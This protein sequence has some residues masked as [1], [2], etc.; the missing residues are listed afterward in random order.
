MSG[1]AADAGAGP[2]AFGEV[3]SFSRPSMPAQRAALSLVGQVRRLFLSD[4]NDPP[5]VS[6][7]RLQS[8]ADKTGEASA[9]A[10]EPL[11]DGLHEAL[12]G[13]LNDPSPACSARV[14]VTPPCE[15]TGLLEAWARRHDLDV[16]DPPAA[17][18]LLGGEPPPDLTGESVLVVPRLE[19]WFL[20]HREGL[21]HVRALLRALSRL[22]RR[23]LVGCNSWAWAFL[24]KA[25]EADSHLPRPLTFEPMDGP[26]LRAWFGE[27][28]DGSG[29]TFRMA[30]TGE[31]VFPGGEGDAPRAFFQRLAAESRGIPWVAWWLWRESLRVR[32]PDEDEGEEEGDD[33]GSDDREPGEEAAV[34]AAARGKA[35]AP[36]EVFVR[37]PEEL[38]VPDR[39]APDE[40]LVL[41]ALL[42]HDRL[43]AAQL[44]DVVPTMRDTSILAA[45]LQA[46]LVE[47]SGD[48][49]RCRP[50]AYPAIRSSL[51]A[52]GFPEDA[53]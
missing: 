4:G 44:Y 30:D 24:V 20:R 14:V 36:D 23:C 28:V 18:R 27:V 22:E 34:D 3:G 50:A 25:V 39:H 47:R 49:A 33:N 52:A 19:D 2:V 51:V 6:E 31:A 29:T 5:Y 8:A 17:E 41:Q 45:L 12:E 15:R 1:D 42:I 32:V 53:L 26:R 48:A 9:P 40:L 37:P 10:C 13:W 16:L 11:L 43:T 21:D 38:T 46:G 7:D 35:Y